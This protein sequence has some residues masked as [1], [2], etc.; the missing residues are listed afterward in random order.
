MI[1]RQHIHKV[2]LRLPD[3]WSNWNLELLVFKERGKL[4]HPEKNLSE[5]R[6]EPTTSSTHIWRPRR[7]QN[8]DHTGG[9]RVVS[10]LRHPCYPNKKKFSAPNNRVRPISIVYRHPDILKQTLQPFDLVKSQI[11]LSEHYSAL[12]LPLLRKR[13]LST[14]TNKTH[15]NDK[16][17]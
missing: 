10:P 7:D 17:V 1:W 16:R 12:Q 11:A 4:E 8:P 5:K 15:C 13:Y 14:K 3:S 9:R 2:V 6:R